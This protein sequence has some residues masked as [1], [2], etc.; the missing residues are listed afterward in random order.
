MSDQDLTG[1]LRALGT[2]LEATPELVAGVR[3]RLDGIETLP[4]PTRVRRRRVLVIAL[5][6][7][8]ALAATA[9]ASSQSIRN[10]LVH[11]GVDARTVETLPPTQRAT[12]ADLGRRIDAAEA[13][14]SLGRRLPHSPLLGSS[15]DIRRL[16]GSTDVT[17]VW[18]ARDELPQTS[19]LPGVGALLTIWP[20]SA[21]PEAFVIGKVLAGTTKVSFVRLPA[22]AEA[23]WVEGAPHAVRLFGNETVKFRMAANA[24][25]W[26]SDGLNLR[27]ET[28]LPLARALAIAGS[29]EPVA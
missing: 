22:G 23:V 24:L 16:A 17:L 26:T 8:L 18:Q 29:L 7:M 12:V 3:E 27:L 6:L 4:V 28:T 25:I 9:V 14:R 1:A 10:W 15:D 11:R 21:S 5:A 13:A 19:S 20:T 2:R